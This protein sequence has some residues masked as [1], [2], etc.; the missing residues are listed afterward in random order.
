V[1]PLG[2]SAGYVEP[3]T[4]EGMSWAVASARALAPLVVGGW[5]PELPARWDRLRAQVVRRRRCQLAA[6]LLRRPRLVGAVAS[7]LA[8]APGLGAAFARAV[9][10]R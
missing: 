8:H 7:L 1:L 4:G 9:H 5:S 3:F 2:D 6:A 10:A